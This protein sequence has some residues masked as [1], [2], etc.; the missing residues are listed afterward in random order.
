[1]QTTESPHLSRS[2]RK[3]M[4][5]TAAALWFI[6]T[7][8][9]LTGSLVPDLAPEDVNFWRIVLGIPAVLISVVLPLL[10]SRLDDRK[11]MWAV[12]I[13]MT[14]A[15]VIYLPILQLT[16]ATIPILF[17]MLVTIIYAGFFL[18]VRDLLVMLSLATLVALSTLFTKVPSQTAH[19][20]S[21]LTVYIPSMWAIAA[22][23]KVQKN[24][25]QFAL[26]RARRQARIDP[27]TKLANLRSLSEQATIAFDGDAPDDG[28]LRALLLID[29]DNFKSANTLHGHIGGDR[30]L[31]VV[32]NYLREVAPRG[33]TVARIGGDEFA[34]L[35]RACD[36]Q[37]VEELAEVFRSAVIGA[38]VDLD[39]EGVTLDA[40]VGVAIHP[41]GGET[42]DELLTTA[43]I[44]M[45]EQKSERP[46]VEIVKRP[47]AAPTLEAI[48]SAPRRQ[49]WIDRLRARHT[50]YAISSIAAWTFGTSVIGISMLMPGAF[51]VNVPLTVLTLLGGYLIALAIYFIDPIGGGRW[52]FFFDFAS[53]GGILLIT[54]LTGGVSSPATTLLILQVTSQAWF[55]REQHVALRIIGPILVILATVPID[56]ALGRPVTIVDIATVYAVVSVV[57]VLTVVMY[58]NQRALGKLDR[59]ATRLALTDPLT[60]VPNRRA[61]ELALKDMLIAG[62]HSAVQPLAIVMIDLDDFKSVNTQHGHRTGDI[63][64]ADIANSLDSVARADDLLAR[65]GG[66]EFAALL[67]GVDVDGARTIAERFIAAVET[68]PSAERHGVGA[69]AGFALSPLHGSSFDELITVADSALMSVKNSDKG[70]TRVG[71]I[72]SAA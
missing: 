22:M 43:D 51:D 39:L 11:F 31:R 64:L 49:T 37:R 9:I 10:L 67:P 14:G 33:S 60:G 6:T 71:R 52:H 17:S 3:L 15:T 44:A 21:W 25:I 72:V 29:L 2:E 59:R 46:A 18:P 47:L 36:R 16:P 56:L 19:L 5:Q 68:T 24:Q 45:Y 35:L 69:S 65:I 4:T 7:A 58:F 28:Q 34:V 30:A 62:G 61:F 63:V 38:N 12:R 32:G 70:T 53:M 54:V 1:M 48:T 41:E 13:G 26:N 55:W 27:L 50:D 23:L 66:D 8:I 20:E 40:S 42:L 57:L